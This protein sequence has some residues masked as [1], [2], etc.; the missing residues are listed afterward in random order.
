MPRKSRSRPN[1]NDVFCIFFQIWEQ[2]RKMIREPAAEA[3]PMLEVPTI[4]V[5]AT[6]WE[7]KP[8]MKRRKDLSIFLQENDPFLTV[9][10]FANN[11]PKK[12]KRKKKE[13]CNWRSVRFVE[14]IYLFF[15]GQ[16]GSYS[17]GRN[18]VDLLILQC[19][20]YM[21]CQKFH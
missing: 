7:K 1:A 10:H 8:K 9:W 6:I 17:N 2:G 16:V 12:K 21:R 14:K 5:F 15:L 13:K 11:C 19:R 18:V 20:L 4:H 3:L